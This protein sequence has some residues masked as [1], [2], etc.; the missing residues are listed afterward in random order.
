MCNKKDYL[1]KRLS[2]LN[3]RYVNNNSAH[4]PSLIKFELKTR[5]E[6]Y[7]L[8]RLLSFFKVKWISGNYLGYRNDDS[9]FFINNTLVLCNKSRYDDVALATTSSRATDNI[10]KAKEV[11]KLLIKIK[12]DYKKEER[13]NNNEIK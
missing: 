12:D 3:I 2:E 1:F 11:L 9:N 8:C 10:Y 5:D 4:N 6:W 13:L 7:K